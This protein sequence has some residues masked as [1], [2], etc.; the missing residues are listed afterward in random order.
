MG[1]VHRS[2][3]ESTQATDTDVLWNVWHTDEKVVQA[4]TFN[5]FEVALTELSTNLTRIGIIEHKS[6][7]DLDRSDGFTFSWDLV[8]R[9]NGGP[10]DFLFNSIE[11]S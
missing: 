11:V 4:N 6:V 7:F 5:R 1:V 2:G 8:V 3:P 10:A 9:T